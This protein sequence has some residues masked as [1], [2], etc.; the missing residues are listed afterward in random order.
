[1]NISN[2]SNNLFPDSP[3]IC[4]QLNMNHVVQIL[5]YVQTYC[6][7]PVLLFGIIF[8]ILAL[9]TLLQPRLK[10]SPYIHLTGLAAA[11]VTTLLLFFIKFYAYHQ[12]RVWQIYLCYVYY[13]LT[14]TFA[15]LIVWT[16]VM[17]TLE[18]CV[19][20]QFPLWAPIWCTT[21]G[22]KFRLLLVF[23]A[24]IA[25]NIPR[26]FWYQVVPVS[27][28][29]RHN[30][31]AIIQPG[32]RYEMVKNLSS[33]SFAD[34]LTWMYSVILN[35][36]PNAILLV[37]NC[38]II[39]KIHAQQKRR[40]QLR[41]QKTAEIVHAQKQTRLTISLIVITCLFTLLVLPSAFVHEN[42][43]LLLFQ[44]RSYKLKLFQDVSTFLFVINLSFNFLMYT[45]INMKFKRAFKRM[46]KQWCITIQ[47]RCCVFGVANAAVEVN[48]AKISGSGWGKNQVNLRCYPMSHYGRLSSP[49]QPTSA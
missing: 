31:S 21:S 41:I 22:A 26:F 19:L 23:L 34:A 48:S 14:N 36:L 42:I 10:E 24:A 18:R 43:A 47:R 39:Y 33:S 12:E 37:T 15:S 2:Q 9:L 25:V 27:A 32:T 7:P 17:M 46:L 30:K 35:F 1:M 28:S 49:S 29:N 6:G 5:N 3:C 38:F 16:M 44:Q 40:S 13:P 45:F 11:N 4:S 8:N 20:I